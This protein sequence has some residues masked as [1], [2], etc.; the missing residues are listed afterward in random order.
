MSKSRRQRYKSTY[1]RSDSEPFWLSLASQIVG[2][3][4]LARIVIAAIVAPVTVLVASPIVDAIYLRYFYAQE[5]VIVP[6]IV[7]AAMGLLMYLVGWR[8]IVGTAGV[9]SPIS[10]GLLVYLVC[11]ALLV[12]AA[13]VWT[14][15][16]LV[17]GNAAL[18]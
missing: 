18:A 11:A 14:L 12:I 13:V 7:A 9:N 3:P 16:L 5:T 2:L 1:P 17:M 15:R 4:R 8:I 10:R 6:S